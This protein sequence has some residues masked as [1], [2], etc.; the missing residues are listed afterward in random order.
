MTYT[1]LLL[2]RSGQL[3]QKKWAT[4]TARVLIYG[5]DAAYEIWEVLAG[6]N[7]IEIISA[8]SLQL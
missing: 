2:E 7:L 3:K 8:P 5:V 6:G 1:V 4:S